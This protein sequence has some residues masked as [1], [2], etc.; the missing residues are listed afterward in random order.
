MAGGPFRIQNRHENTER[1]GPRQSDWPPTPIHILPPAESPRSTLFP[2]NT[3]GLAWGEQP[4]E[5]SDRDY[6]AEDLNLE[7]DFISFHYIFSQEHLSSRSFHPGVGALNVCSTRS[8]LL[9]PTVPTT[10]Q[11]G[12]KA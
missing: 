8:C 9:T 10:L 3:H 11:S 7:A 5:Q 4:I 6:G 2:P 1:A 12:M